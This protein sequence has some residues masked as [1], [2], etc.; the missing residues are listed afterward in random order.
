MG[1][2]HRFRDSAARGEAGVSLVKKYLDTHKQVERYRDASQDEQW[3]GLD[4]VAYLSD[5]RRSTIEVKTDEAS[6]RTGRLAFETW[7]NRESGRLGWAW[8]SQADW[9]VIVM[10]WD[11]S[12]LW[13]NMAVLREAMPDIEAMCVGEI[14][15][16]D[17][18]EA[19]NQR[20]RE[21]YTSVVCCVPIGV[22]RR[23]ASRMTAIYDGGEDA[24]G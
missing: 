4:I 3:Q 21:R 11:G 1:T 18:R 7:S 6:E 13:Y 17:V 15:G 8:T 2:V 23:Y 20:G 12:A 9:L 24:A 22:A 10:P 5:G 14:E 19:V 16:C